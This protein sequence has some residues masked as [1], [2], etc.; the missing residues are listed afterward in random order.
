[1]FSD[2]QVGPQAA[3]INVPVETSDLSGVRSI[4]DF[5]CCHIADEWDRLLREFSGISEREFKFQPTATVHS[6][7]WHVRHAVEWRYALVH[8]LIC[9]QRNEEHL[10]CLGWENEPLV[11]GLSS[12]RSWHEPS[13][14]VTEDVRFAQKVCAITKMDLLS[15]SPARYWDTVVF[16]WRTNR[17]LDEL[18]QDTR[19]FALHRGH[20]REIRKA[21]AR[22]LLGT[23]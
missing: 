5:I 10:T 8:V 13:Y 19:H 17:L 1:M 15:L 4:L 6:I 16:P 3:N 9:G 11:Q 12:I 21:Y 20:V 18:F 2:S 22:R 7:G 14:T 23:G